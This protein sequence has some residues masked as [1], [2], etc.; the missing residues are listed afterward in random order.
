MTDYGLKTTKGDA[1]DAFGTPLTNSPA[2]TK[3][4]VGP[5]KR[6]FKRAFDKVARTISGREQR[7]W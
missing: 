6:S 4:P 2:P 7:R 3:D 1:R 5:G